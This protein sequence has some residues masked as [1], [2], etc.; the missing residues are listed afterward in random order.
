MSTQRD[1]RKFLHL[2]TAQAVLVKL[3][4]AVVLGVALL[5][6]MVNTN[7]QQAHASTLSSSSAS[8]AEVTGM[9]NQV[10]GPDAPGALRVAQCESG[11]NPNA[12]NSMYIGNSRATGVFQ[13]LYPSTWYSTSQASASPYD[14]YANVRAAHD[15]FVRDGHSWREWVCQP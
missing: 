10:F 2:S 5:G 15:I 12:V 8:A 7:A 4:L 14:A 6:V 11:L 13:I 3:G 9:I 1:N